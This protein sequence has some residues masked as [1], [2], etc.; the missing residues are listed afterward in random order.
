MKLKESSKEF[1]TFFVISC[2][3]SMICNIYIHSMNIPSYQFFAVMLGF[4]L[5]ISISYA[6]GFSKGCEKVY[7]IC[8]KEVDSM[9]REKIEELTRKK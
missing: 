9:I 8:D 6:I 4:L 3:I 7:E 5:I 1:L 2:V